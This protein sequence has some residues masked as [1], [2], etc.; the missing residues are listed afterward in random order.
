M[1][2]AD[3]LLVFMSPEGILF[4]NQT[5]DPWYR[6]VLPVHVSGLGQDYL[7]VPDGA[8]S[9]LGCSQRYQYC[10]SRKNCGN[11][12]SAIDAVISASALFHLTPNDLW[13]NV[14]WGR[15]T[16]ATTSRFE[17]F[18]NAL[19]ASSTLYDLLSS[20]GPSSLLS[21]QHLGQDFMG[22]LPDNQWQLDVSHWFAMRMASLQAAF[23]NS[24]RGPTDE[25][26]LPY[27]KRPSDEYQ[28]E[29]CNNQVSI[30]SIM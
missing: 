15:G 21:T 29:M 16:D 12:T 18:Q 17:V 9:P 3:L 8:A 22:P 6:A 28:Q 27:I 19:H 26:L 1:S 25:A 2:D 23:V 20:L 13:T 4:L 24:A 30:N 14:R 10:D 11:L 7:Y 5:T